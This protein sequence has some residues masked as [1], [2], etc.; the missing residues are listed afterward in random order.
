MI[1]ENCVEADT[2]VIFRLYEKA[3]DFQKIKGAV[4]WPGF[5]PILIKT[6]IADCRQ[7]KILID[8]QVAC[9]WATT[10]S[11]PEIWEVLNKDPSV[12]IHRIATNPVFRGHKLVEEIVSWSK[13]YAAVNGKKFIRMD[14]IAG[15]ASLNNY[16]QKCGLKF[17]GVVK[18]KETGSL[19]AHYHDATVSLFQIKLN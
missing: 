1:I 19:P 13:K 18:L 14:T 5:D 7:W 17:L 10:F 4:V 9:V 11:D 6:E 8:H 12:Y 2:N 3:R 15:N 16:Y